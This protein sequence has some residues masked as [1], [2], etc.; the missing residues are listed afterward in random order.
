MDRMN[1]IKTKKAFEISIFKSFILS[2]LFIHV[3]FSFDVRGL[4]L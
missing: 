1:R 2:I 3:N 4:Y